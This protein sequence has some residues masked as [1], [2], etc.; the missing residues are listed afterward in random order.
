MGLADDTCLWT[1]QLI[2][3][4]EGTWIWV[5][6]QLGSQVRPSA[7]D[8]I[9]E[10]LS[11]STDVIPVELNLSKGHRFP[12]VFKTAVLTCAAKAFFDVMVRSIN[13]VLALDVADP[14]HGVLTNVDFKL[15]SGGEVFTLLT[16]LVPC[17]NLSR[18][19]VKLVTSMDS[20]LL[21][22]CISEEEFGAMQGYSKHLG[23]FADLRDLLVNGASADS[24]AAVTS[25]MK[26][27]QAWASWELWKASEV[28]LEYSATLSKLAG[29]VFA[30]SL[31]KLSMSKLSDVF[32]DLGEQ[33]KLLPFASVVDAS[34]SGDDEHAFAL[35]LGYW[36]DKAPFHNFWVASSSALER[37][38]D[39]DLVTR[40]QISWFNHA[41]SLMQQLGNASAELMTHLDKD[42]IHDN[43]IDAV[44][45]SRHRL[46]AFKDLVSAFV[47]ETGSEPLRLD[48]KSCERLG[49]PLHCHY[50]GFDEFPFSDTGVALVTIADKLLKLCYT[51]WL[52]VGNKLAQIIEISAPKWEPLSDQLVN[53][54]GLGAGMRH[55]LLTNDK[56][57]YL[58]NSVPKL[59]A[60]TKSVS[61]IQKDN[62]G[63]CWSAEDSKR[64]SKAKD[65][66]YSTIN[67]SYVLEQIFTKIKGKG[68]K[69]QVAAMK[70]LVTKA[71]NRK[72]SIPT[73]LWTYMCEVAKV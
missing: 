36:S 51:R 26:M 62:F 7:E 67:T 8:A 71:D 48:S 50:L 58:Q 53:D 55:E 64:L 11:A 61:R 69:I 15:D 56:I 60:I 47:R 27:E 25:S 43:Y 39:S 34:R 73:A 57:T 20:T 9:F 66:G 13:A 45:K 40:H 16:D 19:V 49:V 14:T 31:S 54:D 42:T 72:K 21:R 18:R 59:M 28:G 1:D 68:E 6:S 32:N 65:F 52:D 24:L 12:Q 17:H 30:Q 37:M 22:R 38:S 41:S 35:K 3:D 29:S 33:L 10:M 5:N 4:F 2:T 23:A 46:W 44:T 63:L 70:A